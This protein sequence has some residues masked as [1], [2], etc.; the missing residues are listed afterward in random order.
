VKVTVA[1]KSVTVEG[2]TPVDLLWGLMQ[3]EIAKKKAEQQHHAT[4]GN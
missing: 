1:D 3:K 2:Q 4:S